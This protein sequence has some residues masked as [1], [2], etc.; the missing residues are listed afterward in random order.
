MV[1][2]PM[3]ARGEALERTLLAIARTANKRTA[4]LLIIAF[5]LLQST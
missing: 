1:I 3:G 5:P 4:G 2:A